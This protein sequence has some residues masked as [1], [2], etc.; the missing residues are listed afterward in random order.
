MT[1]L[2]VLIPVSGNNYALVDPE[3]VEKVSSMSWHMVGRYAANGSIYMHR[4]VMGLS[5]GD[6]HVDHK[7]GNGLDNRK[8]NLR[9]ATYQQNTASSIRVKQQGRA[10]HGKPTRTTSSRFRGVS[11]RTDRKRWTAYIGTAKDRTCLG[12]FEFEE[13]AARAYNEAALVKYGE[14]A[15]LN[16][17]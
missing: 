8:S 9:L 5:S 15:R 11:Y 10:L 2:P 17:L 13:Q 14:F 7:N 4:V 3:D 12:C 6:S 16:E 1:I